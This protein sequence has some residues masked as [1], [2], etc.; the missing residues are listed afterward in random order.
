MIS[1]PRYRQFGEA[2]SLRRQQLGMTQA[3]LAARVGLS[4]ASIANIEAGRQSVLLHH[5]CDVASALKLRAVTDLLPTATALSLED[6]AL[7]LS[8]DVSPAAKAQISGMI[9]AAMAVARPRQ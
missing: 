8:D 7:E 9:A 6:Q 4:R 2:M 3:E 1:D 5:A